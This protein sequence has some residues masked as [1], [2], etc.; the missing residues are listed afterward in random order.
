VRLHRQ[1]AEVL[2]YL[3]AA[4]IVHRDVKPGNLMVEPGGR[5]RLLDLG[6]AAAAADGLES[7]RTEGGVGTPRYMSPEQVLGR[8]VSGATDVYALGLCL[9]EAVAGVGPFEDAGGEAAL[10]AAQVHRHAPRLSAVVPDVPAALDAVVATCLAKEASNRH[11]S[12]E[13]LAEDL[14]L[15]EE[16]DALDVGETIAGRQLGLDRVRSDLPGRGGQLRALTRWLDR[17]PSLDERGALVLLRGGHGSGRTALLAWAGQEARR[18]GL[19]V[20]EGRGSSGAGPAC[21]RLLD[22]ARAAPRPARGELVIATASSEQRAPGDLPRTAA[23]DLSPLGTA[24]IG[25]WARDEVGVASIAQ[26]DL[27]FLAEVSGGW[28]GRLEPLLFRWRELRRQGLAP[29]R[30]E[31][32]SILQASGEER[33]RTAELLSSLRS[34]QRLLL[35]LAAWLDPCSASL[36]ALLALAG[37]AESE[38]PALVRT[39]LEAALGVVVQEGRLEFRDPIVPRVVREATERQMKPELAAA[40]A[41]LLEGRDDAPA[42]RRRAELLDEV[43]DASAPS[44]AW[45]AAGSFLADG[46]ELDSAETVD[47]WLERRTEE[48]D[49]DERRLVARAVRTFMEVGQVERAERLLGRAMTCT[50]RE[51]AERFQLARARLYWRAGRVHEAMAVYLGLARRARERGDVAGRFRALVSLAAIDKVRGR[52]RRSL[53]LLSLL[54]P[55]AEQAPPASRT[56][57]LRSFAGSLSL[58]GRSDEAAGLLERASALAEEHGLHADR[59]ALCEQ[60]ALLCFSDGRTEE[61]DRILDEAISVTRR[62]GDVAHRAY[63]QH[64]L[65]TSQL[66]QGRVEA[67]VRLLRSSQRWAFRAGDRALA[68]N[69]YELLARVEAHHGHCSEGRRLLRLARRHGGGDA[70][71][72]AYARLAEADLALL[73]GDAEAAQAVFA[74]AEKLAH[75]LD[76]EGKVFRDAVRILL[77]AERGER[78]AARLELDALQAGFATSSFGFRYEELRRRAAGGRS[79]RA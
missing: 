18:R 61:A 74:E 23:V 4:G 47:A 66:Q 28:P 56:G 39:T 73:D 49:E 3:H 11:R 67:A 33:R 41:E 71:L 38:L 68:A 6:I 19:H 25:R 22:D 63:F 64:L 21:V 57:W 62:I 37:A 26:A 60:R 17:V 40:A 59:L 54:E 55:L 77:S 1:L 43:G 5:L 32:R 46:R 53:R 76:A 13:E 24:S 14:R 79:A 42:L 16:R 9:F 15:L 2:S 78:R 20:I 72:E 7:R 65:A 50:G 51:D 27:A 45:R 75:R 70:N 36:E 69:N 30:G 8:P 12:A 31:L 44:L 58:Q 52:L 48:L 35:E 34:G 29:D 10:L